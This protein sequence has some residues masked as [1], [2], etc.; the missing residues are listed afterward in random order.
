MEFSGFRKS[1]KRTQFFKIQWNRFE[2][3]WLWYSLL[4]GRCFLKPNL[5]YSCCLALFFSWYSTCQWDLPL[6][7]SLNFHHLF[8][9]L[10]RLS[11]IGFFNF[12]RLLLSF[13]KGGFLP[14]DDLEENSE[15]CLFEFDYLED[16]H[17]FFVEVFSKLH[18]LAEGGDHIYLFFDLYLFYDH[19]VI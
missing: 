16:S 11:K 9:A 6:T 4:F 5:L 8:I 14:F 17:V 2:L 7:E 10:D 15:L 19:R 12:S 13:K 3:V 18:F 1:Y